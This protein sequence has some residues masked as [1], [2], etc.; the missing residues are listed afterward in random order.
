MSGLDF[1][2]FALAIGVA[3]ALLAGCGGLQPPVGASGAM[4]QGHAIATH[5]RG[6][7]WIL[8]LEVPLP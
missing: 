3:A 6:G 1:G 8:C 2:R 7:S 4:P 5:D